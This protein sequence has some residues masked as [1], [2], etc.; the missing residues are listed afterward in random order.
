MNSPLAG[1]PP[2]CGGFFGLGPVVS[3]RSTSSYQLKSL[4]LE[5]SCL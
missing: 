3:L 1:T 4:R 2:A 5:E